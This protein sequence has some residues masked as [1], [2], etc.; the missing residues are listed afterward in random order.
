[1]DRI[2]A[3]GDAEPASL[4][5]MFRKVWALGPAGTHIPMSIGRNDKVLEVE[6]ISV[7][8]SALLKTGT[9]H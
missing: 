8:R 7:D 6:L 3:I 2:L 4:A 9:V 1:G 5:D